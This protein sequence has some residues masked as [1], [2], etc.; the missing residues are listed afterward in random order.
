MSWRVPTVEEFTAGGSNSSSSSCT[1][2][3]SVE[4]DSEDHY[5]EG[6]RSEAMAE[7]PDQLIDD[8]ARD[9]H[10]RNSLLTQYIA[11]TCALPHADP[12]PGTI[13]TFY[14]GNRIKPSSYPE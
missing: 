4:P 3:I 6:R 14:K 7:V 10:N 2:N 8:V 1:Y 9:Q 13:L 5:L 12:T 11:F